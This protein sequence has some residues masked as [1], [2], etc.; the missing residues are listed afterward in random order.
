MTT[1]EEL[2]AKGAAGLP[3]EILPAVMKRLMQKL[4]TIRV[5][6]YYLYQFVEGDQVWRFTSRAASWTSAGLRCPSADMKR[7]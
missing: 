4:L 7:L 3:R 6:P 1:A 2:A 5:R